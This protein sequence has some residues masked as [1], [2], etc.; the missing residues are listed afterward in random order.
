[1]TTSAQCPVRLSDCLSC[2][3]TSPGL[4]TTLTI[5]RT[6]FVTR[7]ERLDDSVVTTRS[8]LLGHLHLRV[9]TAAARARRHIGSRAACPYHYTLSLRISEGPALPRTRCKRSKPCYTEFVSRAEDGV[10][11]YTQYTNA[12]GSHPC[13]V[14]KGYVLVLFLLGGT[15]Q[16]S[17]YT[18]GMVGDSPGPRTLVSCSPFNK[19]TQ[20]IV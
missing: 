14:Y 12:E 17:Q 2:K 13:I 18:R 7:E 4:K 10:L 16:R 15:C 5:A 3:L 19:S 9:P 20:Y 8:R 1:M 11:Q 6:P